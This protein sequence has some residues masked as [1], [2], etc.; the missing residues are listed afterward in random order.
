MRYV[1]TAKRLTVYQSVNG[2][3]YDSKEESDRESYVYMLL[4]LTGMTMK[5]DGGREIEGLTREQAERLLDL[6]I[7]RAMDVEDKYLEEMDRREQP[8]VAVYPE[9]LPDVLEGGN[10]EEEPVVEDPAVEE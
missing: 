10:A 8:A 4:E 5:E 3:R 9:E 7:V 6:E 2:Q 1:E